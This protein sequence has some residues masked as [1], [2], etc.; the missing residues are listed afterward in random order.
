MNPELFSE[1]KK[2]IDSVNSDYV[3]RKL[4]PHEPIV[5][6]LRTEDN[7][8]KFFEIS[9]NGVMMLES[10]SGKPDAIV[11]GNSRLIIKLLRGEEDP[12]KSFFLGKVKVEGS[13]DFAYIIHERLREYR[14]IKKK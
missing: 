2:I 6:E 11:K 14:R 4:L 8:S 9:E 10:F 13:L 1:L 3:L 7:V 12:I 5:V